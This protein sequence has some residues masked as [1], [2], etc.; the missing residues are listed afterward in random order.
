MC[1]AKAPGLR[2]SKVIK[3]TFEIIQKNAPMPTHSPMGNVVRPIH[4]F[5]GETSF[6]GSNMGELN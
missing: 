4:E 3:K 1:V 6:H 2:E 5:G